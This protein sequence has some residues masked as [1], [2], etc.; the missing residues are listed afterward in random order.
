[1]KPYTIWFTG[2]SGSGKTTLGSHLSSLMS[3]INIPV[4]FL[5]GDNM[6][7]GIYKD[8]GYTKKD[9]KEAT[10]RI[11]EICRNIMDS[12]VFVI[13]CVVSP[14]NSLVKKKIKDIYEIEVDCPLEVCIKRDV[15]GLY[16]KAKAGEIKNLVG[17]NTAKEKTDANLVVKTD[18]ASVTECMDLLFMELKK[19]MII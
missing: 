8:L 14:A 4:V 7:K 12:G 18:K 11:A 6:R 16:K 15:K 19:E 1:M 17:Y 9:R 2:I 10:I 5:D 3:N 13:V